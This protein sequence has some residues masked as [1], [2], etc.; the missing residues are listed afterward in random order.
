M[1]IK[2]IPFKKKKEMKKQIWP[3]CDLYQQIIINFL[4]NT[5]SCKK[6]QFNSSSIFAPNFFSREISRIFVFQPIEKN[7]C[8]HTYTRMHTLLIFYTRPCLKNRCRVNDMVVEWL[9]YFH[10]CKFNLEHGPRGFSSPL[11]PL[12]ALVICAHCAAAIHG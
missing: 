4:N 12:C 9:V 10:V 7:C 3:S 2:Y 11:S 5:I 6:N 1:V 8:T